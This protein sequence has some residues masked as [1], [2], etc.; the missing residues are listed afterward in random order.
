MGE[1]L[2]D[3]EF[4]GFLKLKRDPKADIITI[5]NC[6]KRGCRVGYSEWICGIPIFVGMACTLFNDG[7]K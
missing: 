3:P 2:R 7:K 1:N 6:I 5:K 4:K